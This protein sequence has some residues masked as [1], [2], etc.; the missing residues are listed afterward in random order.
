MVIR[1]CSARKLV[2]YNVRNSAARVLYHVCPVS[3]CLGAA[4]DEMR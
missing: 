4:M 3:L 2:G 1:N